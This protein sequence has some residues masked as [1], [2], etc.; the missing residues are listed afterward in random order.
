VTGDEA[1]P[2]DRLRGWPDGND[3]DVTD[4]WDAAFEFVLTESPW[5]DL[6]PD[7]DTIPTQ[8]RSAPP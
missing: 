5:Y 1:L 2:S 8:A 7:P 4:V 3:E 6:D